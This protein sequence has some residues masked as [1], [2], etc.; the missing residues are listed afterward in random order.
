MTSHRSRIWKRRGAGAALWVALTA[1]F[2]LA[3]PASA[4]AQ[5]EECPNVCE[6]ASC[7]TPCVRG[8]VCA[9]N[10]ANGCVCACLVPPATE[11][12]CTRACPTSRPF[13]KNLFLSLG[14]DFE[15]Y[16]A[17]DLPLGKV[18][19]IERVNL[20]I[21]RRT[22]DR[23]NVGLATIFHDAAYG[24]P[25]GATELVWVPVA[26]GQSYAV[27]NNTFQRIHFDAGVV[28]KSATEPLRLYVSHAEQ[29]KPVNVVAVITGTVEE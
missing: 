25:N 18:I 5:A 7:A 11:P 17:V 15:D 24:E 19:T 14:S 26:G 20:R 13:Q 28:H 1:A 6:V 21:T 4:R 12:G 3:A 23:V 9:P 10:P 2:V 27:G 8:T 16:A 22:T 29:G